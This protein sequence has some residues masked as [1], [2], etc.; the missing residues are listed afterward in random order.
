MPLKHIKITL[1]LFLFNDIFIII[2]QHEVDNKKYKYFFQFSVFI[3]F[4]SILERINT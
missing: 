4:L 2:N 1:I 3:A